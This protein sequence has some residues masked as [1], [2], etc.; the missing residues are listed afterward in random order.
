MALATIVSRAEALEPSVL[1]YLHACGIGEEAFAKFSDDRQIAAEELDAIRRIAVRLR[2]CPADRL[3]RMMLPEISAAERSGTRLRVAPAEAKRQRGRVCQLQGSLASVERVDDQNGEPLWRCSVTLSDSPQRAVVYTA[4]AL[5]VP[6]GY[7]ALMV[8]GSPPKGGTTSERVTVDGVFVKYVPAGTMSGTMYPWS[9]SAVEPMAVIVAPRV[10]WRNDSPLGDLGM[11]FGLLQGIQDQSALTAADH[12]AFYR[13]LLL[14]KNADPARLGNHVG[15]DVPMVAV[16]DAADLDG[17]SPGLPALFHDPQAG[18]PA[19]QRGRLVKLSGKACRV[20]RVPVDDPAVATR[21]GADH[22]FEIDLVAN[23][24]PACGWQGNPLVFCTLHLPDGMPLG[25]P[26]SYG[27]GVEVTGFFLKTW[28]Y[29]TVLSQ[30]EKEANP[31]SSRAMQTAPLLIG[32]APLWKPAAISTKSPTTGAV[33]GLLVL[34][35]IGVC[36]LLLSIRQSD[37]EFFRQVIARQR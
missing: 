22:Y 1:D 6:P 28:Q 2:D 5:A 30:G 20:V 8:G 3:Q 16:G 17:S 24:V 36:L 10:Q 34:A 32:P 9:R 4:T 15:H 11:D 13:L 35:M 23:R 14:A 19:A 26:P 12:D 29:P 33:V 31:A 7:H 37:Q 21:L 27:E 25:G 18:T